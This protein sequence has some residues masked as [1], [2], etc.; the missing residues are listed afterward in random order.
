M[1]NNRNGKKNGY[2]LT[3]VILS[4]LAM[5]LLLLIVGTGTP[6]KGFCRFFCNKQNEG[7]YELVYLEVTVTPQPTEPLPTP[8][9]DPNGVWCT[10]GITRCTLSSDGQCILEESHYCCEFRD[11]EVVPATGFYYKTQV[12]ICA[13]EGCQ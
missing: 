13:A 11:H 10:E 3:V 12:G 9:E 1:D 6:N 2:I 7:P 5:M 8:T 4:A